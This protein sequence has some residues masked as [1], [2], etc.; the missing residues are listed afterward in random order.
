VQDDINAARTLEQNARNAFTTDYNHLRSY[1]DLGSG[2]AMEVLEPIVRSVLTGTA[3]TYLSYGQRALEVLEKVKELQAKI[4]KSEPKPT[5]EKF[6][7]RDVVFPTRQYPRFFMGVLATDV[8]TPANW[9]W[10][11]DLRGVSSDPDLSGS[12][13][14]L[15]LSLGETGDGVRRHGAFDGQADFRSSATERFN[16]EVSGGGFPVSMSISQ[17]GIGG[18]SG[19]TSFTVNVAGNVGGG[20]MLGGDV[21]LAQAR[22]TNPSNTFAQA[23]GEAIGQVRSVDFGIQYE[24]V[25]SGRDRFSITTN[26]DD[27]LKDALGRIVSR[28][29]RQAEEA[30]EKALR[31]KIE[32]YIDGRFVSKDDLD[33]VFR[34]VRGDKS[35]VDELRGTLDRKKNELEDRLRSAGTQIV[36]DVREQVRVE[37]QQAVQDLLQGT[38]PSTPSINIPNPFRR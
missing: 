3:E 15:A 25:V 1:I 36:D 7:G 20:F 11:F 12:P 27:I 26:F 6:K 2:A 9:H 5:V 18:F 33:A 32:Q 17:A 13:T 22:L 23:A 34:L 28:Y 4:P 16:A 24:H 21:S 10:A 29:R 31:G 19:D 38:T 35:A 37:A 30:L 8:L 14:S